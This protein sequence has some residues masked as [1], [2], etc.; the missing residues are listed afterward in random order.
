MA[1]TK[2]RYQTSRNA[3]TKSI[4]EWWVRDTEAIH[5]VD[6]IV[7][8]AHTE[9]KADQVA[10]AMNFNNKPSDYGYILMD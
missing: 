10:A 8:T 4:W 5:P 7:C 6:K 9:M 2:G 1:T 3:N